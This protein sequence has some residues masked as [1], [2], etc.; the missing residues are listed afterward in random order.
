[1]RVPRIPPDPEEVIGCAAADANR[2]G[3]VFSFLLAEPQHPDD[4]YRHWDEVRRRPPPAGFSAEEHWAALKL[5]RLRSATRLALADV[6]DRP[7]WFTE[8]PA[9]RQ[10]LHRLDR[11]A[12]GV[13]GSRVR[14]LTRDD[15]RRYVARS[16]IE[17]PF[18]S[19]IL[20]GAVTT[21]D[22]A[23]Q[24][25]EDDRPPRT[26]DER[27][28]L[29][30]YRAME[31]VKRKLGEPLTLPLILQIHKI[32]SEGTLDRAEMAGRLRGP[33]DDVRV[34]DDGNDDVL[35]TPP[36]ASDLPHRLEALCAFANTPE[37]EQPF[38][39]PVIRAIILH[40]MIGYEHPF[41]DGN[42]R[43]ARAL[44][45]WGALKAGYWMLEYVSISRTITE[46]PAQYY[47][48]FLETE[49]DGGDLTYFIDHQLRV[50]C[51]SID[52]LHDY[53]ERRQA[54]LES[55]SDAL[56]SEDFNHRQTFVLNEAALKRA[57]R[58]TI[59]EQQRAHNVSYHT[60]RNDLEDLVNRGFLAKV[61]RG[62]GS[63][64]RPVARLLEQFA[65]D[66]GRR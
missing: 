20:E 30:N 44:F 56:S 59:A 7:F 58:F 41:V 17:E 39:H 63:I 16:L 53:V 35:H 32:V 11:D 28:V 38:I 2:A 65:V 22:I 33:K 21:R 55:F 64:Y 36:P 62:R 54:D 1:M 29:N 24:L 18:S 4:P 26:R 27:M 43:T 61:K 6:R 15:S 34:V 5:R 14:A 47:R 23:R 52:A 40:F 45:Y 13:I 9:V 48:A 8:P 10:A 51:K 3:K 12:A 57:T 50:L 37:S 25:V 46:A 19:S 60:A 49:T 66:R 42:G 31:L